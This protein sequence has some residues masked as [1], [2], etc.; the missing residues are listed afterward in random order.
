MRRN[1]SSASSTRSPDKAS[2]E[3][4]APLV[5]IVMST[6]REVADGDQENGAG[7]TLAR[8]IDSVLRQTF[9]NW[10]LFVVSDHPPEA[11]RRRLEAM[12][13]TCT[14]ERIRFLDLPERTGYAR[15][16]I[17]PKC[18][19]ISHARGEL[20]AFLDGD[21]EWTPEHLERAV[22]ELAHDPDIDLVYCDS[23]VHLSEHVADYEFNELM[24]LVILPYRLLGP[25]SG[26]SFRWA[27]PDWN[28]AARRQLEKYNYIDMSEVVL[29]MASFTEAGGFQDHV[30]CDWHLWVEMIRQG[31]GRFRHLNHV[32]LRLRTA[33]LKQHRQLFFLSQI[34]RYDLPFDMQE[35]EKSITAE[36]RADYVK[37]H[38]F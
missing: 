31:K 12:A 24:R 25:L 19:G 28:E 10:E 8:A 2:R 21:N 15:I 6:F 11:D 27:K 9:T 33:S 37:K 17:A 20:L 5:S 23:Q 29:R 1:D 30:T 34:H 3:R 26:E 14:D 22:G 32:G 35:Y 18:L 16:G 38:E 36:R 7:S 4:A 13:R